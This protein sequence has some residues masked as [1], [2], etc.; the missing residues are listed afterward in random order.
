M[1]KENY[2]IKDYWPLIAIFLTGLVV[3]W[4]FSW[5]ETP[6]MRSMAGFMGTVLILLSV[7][8][9]A[10]RSEF[11]RAFSMYDVIASRSKFY[12]RNYPFLELI[13]GIA[14]VAGSYLVLVN[15]VTFLVMSI[16]AY[17]VGKKLAKGEKLMCACLGAVFKVPMTWV[18]LGE[19]VLMAGMALVMLLML[20]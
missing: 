13:L 3:A 7:L 2:T 8:K 19:D 14:Y 15:M 6:L 18:T 5:A 12:A 20:I 10:N 9:I 4:L 17:G 11:A 1:L 16:G